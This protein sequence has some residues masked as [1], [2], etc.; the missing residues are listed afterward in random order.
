MRVSMP[1][2]YLHDL[3]KVG[4]R[5]TEELNEK[6][7]GGGKGISFIDVTRGNSLRRRLRNFG[8]YQYL[9]SPEYWASRI[10]PLAG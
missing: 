7:S 10:V 4:V 2:L 3:Q 5:S 9:P 8:S 6:F 1:S